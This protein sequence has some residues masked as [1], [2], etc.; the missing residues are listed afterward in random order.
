MP[1]PRSF[2]AASA[3]STAKDLAH[4]CAQRW[5]LT[6]LGVGL[7]LHLTA[8]LALWLSQQPPPMRG[9]TALF[10][11]AGWAM[12][13]GRTL[14]VGIWD[15][16]PPLA[17]QLS[18]LIAWVTGGHALLQHAVS[19]GVTIA[20]SMATL[21]LVGQIVHEETGE[22]RAS[23]LAGLAPLAYP[24]F[25]LR[26][27]YGFSP[28]Y[29]ALAFGLG[30]ILASLHRRD[31]IAG[32]LGAASAAVWQFGIV[33]PVLAL[34]RSL[35]R[36]ERWTRCLAGIAFATAV[37]TVPVLLSG[38]GE[39]MI[40][41][42]VIVPL[43]VRNGASPLVQGGDA[44]LFLRFGLG[45]VLVGGLGILWAARHRPRREAWLIALAAWVFVEVVFLDMDGPP[46]LLLAV[47][48][49]ALGLGLIVPASINARR[50]AAGA[51]GLGLVVAA[52]GVGGFGVLFDPVS[53]SRDE[54]RA[55]PALVHRGLQL[56]AGEPED[57]TPPIED[58]GNEDVQALRPFLGGE[59]L[60]ELY[61]NR[62][63]PGT[64]HYRLSM[65]E[66]AWLEQ[67]GRPIRDMDCG[68]WPSELF[69][70]S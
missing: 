64:C 63:L 10:E 7:A 32:A 49:T 57:G 14:Y 58:A 66:L 56:L 17:F 22:P 42:A 4:R 1:G 9:D 13:E 47:A 36:R 16:K 46:D 68:A 41:E 26:P 52:F 53:E 23:L 2:S 45:P 54:Q 6:V 27:A 30:A 20:A 51:V 8:V 35:G 24:W 15:I 65:T 25:F 3:A 55:D 40:V 21:L 34:A 44:L 43:L 62:V 48:T 38:A 69:T 19:V 33:F 59:N 61:W 31:G 11:H 70:T 67:T 39:A 12:T 5:R 18:A 37:V 28:K 29:F 60:P 50:A